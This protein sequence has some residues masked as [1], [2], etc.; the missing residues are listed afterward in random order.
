ME[1][2]ENRKTGKKRVCFFFIKQ[3]FCECQASADLMLVTGDIVDIR[4]VGRA[5]FKFVGNP[6]I[7]E[8]GR[9]L[10]SVGC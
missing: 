5:S 8:E 10:G 9:V 2:K 3:N 4:T 1:G 6:L 7:R